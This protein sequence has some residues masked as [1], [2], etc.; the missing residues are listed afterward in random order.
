MKMRCISLREHAKNIIHFEKKKILT[1]I[2]E[3]LKSIKMQKYVT[4]AEKDFS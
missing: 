2:K 4:F 3:E 1:L